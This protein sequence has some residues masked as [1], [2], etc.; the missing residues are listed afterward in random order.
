MITK[1]RGSSIGRILR[2]HGFRSLNRRLS[3]RVSRRAAP[4]AVS[5]PGSAHQRRPTP[6]SPPTDPGPPGS[7]GR[8]DI[9]PPSSVSTSVRTICSPRPPVSAARSKPGSGPGPLSETVTTRVSPDGGPTRRDVSE[10]ATH[11]DPDGPAGVAEPVLDGV[12]HQ[13]DEH[14][15]ERRGHLGGPAGRR[16]RP[17]RPAPIP[18]RHPRS[19]VPKRP[20][21][22]PGRRP[23]RSRR[24]RRGC[25]DSVSWTSAIE[26]TRRSASASA[27][28]AV[29]SAGASRRRLQ[30]QQRGHGL[31]VVLH[32]VVDLA[33]R[34]VLA[35]QLALAAAQLGDV[36]DEHERRRTHARRACSGMT[37][38][39]TV[40]PAASTSVCRAAQPLITMDSASST[41]LRLP[42]AGST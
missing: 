2:D 4:A 11:L 16:C 8:S 6:C 38:S 29:S 5:T 35:D 18:R 32:P 24:A 23:R 13:L 31:Q 33:D 36:A 10:A 27:A 39:R 28:R 14:Q 21:H 15:R 20:A 40:A 41:G 22:R 37:R 9:S 17:A 19:V 26:P 12:L 25:G 42:G 1:D 34:R 7:T 30:A 3:R